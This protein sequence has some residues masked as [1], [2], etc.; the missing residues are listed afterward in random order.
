MNLIRKILF[1]FVPVYYS[2]TW[3]RNWCY[4][5]NIFDSKAY[6]F[7]V[8]C[9]GNLSVGGTGKTPMIEYLIQLLKTNYKVATLSRGYKRSTKGFQVANYS[10][11][12]ITIG[13]EP[14]QFHQKFD[15]ITVSV[16]SNR[17]HGIAK[18]LGLEPSPDVI[19]LDDA[20]QHR[21]VRAGLNILLT[22]FDELYINDFLLPTGNLREP[23]SGAKRADLII[24]TKCP[25]NISNEKK[26]DII[27]LLKPLKNQQVFF[28]SI[29]Y[30]DTIFS[31]QKR[32]PIESLKKKQFTLVTGIA[33]ATPL[34][35]YLKDE[36]FIFEH[37]NFKDHHVFTDT[38]IEML[39]DKNLVL[40]TEKD[41]TRLKDRVNPSILYYLPIE[42][43][44]IEANKF[45]QIV[46]DFVAVF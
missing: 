1:P 11:T 30:N 6:N 36:R 35:N 37:L 9:V 44:I 32:M 18:L 31:T 19:L 12:A 34:L 24:V 16:D 26:H 41:F 40:T 17:Q 21:K 13:D 14:F 39:N 33:N 38:E 45:N 8:I 4:D 15:D 23:K 2:I 27:N 7:P 46:E 43:K 3:L 28:S 29:D 42:A 5:K 10:S 22:T 20:F 25:K